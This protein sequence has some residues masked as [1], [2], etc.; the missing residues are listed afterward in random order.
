[1]WYMLVFCFIFM[2]TASTIKGDRKKSQEQGVGVVGVREL[3][4]S[5]ALHEKDWTGMGNGKKKHKKFDYKKKFGLH[6]LLSKISVCLAAKCSTM[7]TS[8]QLTLSVS[9]LNQNI[10]LVEEDTKT[11]SWKTQNILHRVRV[12]AASGD[13]CGLWVS[14]ER[15]RSHP[16]SH[17]LILTVNAVYSID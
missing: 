13:N 11:M 15:H 1:M 14:Y 4:Y 2:S 12:T 10:K 3:E 17:I 16:T 6:Q 5:T 9:H 7:F 8:S